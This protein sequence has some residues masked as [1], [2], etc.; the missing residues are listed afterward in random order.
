MSGSADPLDLAHLAE[1]LP[2]VHAELLRMGHTLEQLGKDVQDIEFT[3]EAGRLYLLQTRNA[4]RS[5]DAAIRLAVDLVAD[6]LITS[7]EALT[8]VKPEHVEAVTKPHLSEDVRAAATVLAKG[9]PACPGLAFGRVVSDPHVAIFEAEDGPVVLVRRFTSPD[10][11]HG[12]I[13]AEGICTE[14]GGRTS[15]AAVVSRELGRPCIVGCG[16]GMVDALEGK[17]VTMDGSTGEIFEGILPTVH[18]DPDSDPYLGQL[19]T[20]AA[21]TQPGH[22]LHG[23]ALQAT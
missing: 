18:R 8:R 22:P 17:Q 6:G 3:V 5:P 12:M 7:E 11:V 2:D 23:L 16:A 9:E 21:D 20:W 19:L 10:D 14:V 1:R 4:K 13:A 15:H